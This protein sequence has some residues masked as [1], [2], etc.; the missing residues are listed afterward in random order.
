[1]DE[2]NGKQQGA[3]QPKSLSWTVGLLAD[4]IAC[5][6]LLC[7]ICELPNRIFFPALVEM[8]FSGLE[9]HS[10]KRGANGQLCSRCW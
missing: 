2:T 3:Q 7:L 6:L 4:S 1:M 9:V 10:S 8:G 5:Y